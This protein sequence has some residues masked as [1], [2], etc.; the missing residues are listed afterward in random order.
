ML[1]DTMFRNIRYFIVQGIKGL[2]SNGLMTLASV[3]IVVASLFLFGFF[4]LLGSNLNYISEQIKQQ[5]EI[6]VYLPKTMG[7][8]AVRD[9]GSMLSEIEGVKE[10]RV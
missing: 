5:C 7:R 4:V 1:T 8:D 9:V 3:G 10:V 2:T 6:N